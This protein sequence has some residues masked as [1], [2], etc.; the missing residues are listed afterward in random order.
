ML[1]YAG[2][3]LGG[4]GVAYLQGRFSGASRQQAL[5]DAINGGGQVGGGLPGGQGG[6]Q[7]GGPILGL[8][9]QLLQ[10]RQG[11]HVNG[12]TIMTIL[13]KLLSQGTSPQSMMVDEAMASIQP[14]PM[15][16]L[17][18]DRSVRE[19]SGIVHRLLDKLEE[20]LRPEVSPPQETKSA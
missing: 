14:A 12:T 8:I 17:E 7:V 4:Y 13:Q 20:R 10:L 16:A 5:H 2:I 1:I 18:P 19:L 3:A 15:R 11:G 9:Q 6:G